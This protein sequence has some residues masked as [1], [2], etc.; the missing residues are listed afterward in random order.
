[1]SP[2]IKEIYLPIARF[3][4]HA[5]ASSVGFV[6]LVAATII[7]IYALSLAPAAIAELFDWRLLELAVLYLDIFLYALTVLLWAV[8]FVVEEVR[9]VR[10]LLGW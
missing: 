9:A 2:I 1:M 7:P 6:I 8:V 3:A 5:S 10:K 4:L